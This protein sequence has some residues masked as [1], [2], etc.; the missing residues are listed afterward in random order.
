LTEDNFLADDFLRQL[1]S[2]GEVD[3][4]VGIYAHSNV[5]TIRQTV[6]AIEQSVQQY[7]I[8]QRVVV[9]NV[10]GIPRDDDGITMTT[11]NAP[12]ESILRL[13][14]LTSLRTIRRVAASFSTPPSRGMALRLILSSADLLRAR[15]CAV[16]SSATSNL[17]PEWIR[18]LLEPVYREKVDFVAPL[19]TRH[20]Y[21]GLLARN[22]LYPMSRAVFGRRIRELYPDEWGISGRLATFCLNQHGWHDETIRVRPEAWIGVSASCSDFR[23]C[24]AFLGPKPQSPTGSGTDIVEALR[25]TVGT[26]FWCLE[27]QQ[28]WLDREGSEPVPTFGPDHDLTLEPTDL[29]RQRIFEMFRSGVSELDPILSSILDPQTH[30]EIKSIASVS[31]ERFRFGADLWVRT[32]YDFASSYHHAVINRDHLVQALVPLYRGMLY[33]FLVDHADSSAEEIEAENEILCREFERQKPYLSE[34]WKMRIEV[35]P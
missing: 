33:S 13:P 31:E 15:A 24:Q 9:V 16:I 23:C 1:M 21:Q 22:L 27:S 3:L 28:S 11:L 30:A 25:E 7:F 6:Y 14:G 32:L 5:N 4:L 34:R 20:K 8:R 19:Y 18:N 10:H 35:K 26:L 17:T 2:V 29:N 12:A